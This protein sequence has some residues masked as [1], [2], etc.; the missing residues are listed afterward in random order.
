MKPSD[1]LL[2]LVSLARSAMP[3]SRGRDAAWQIM[4]VERSLGTGRRA[5]ATFLF[6]NSPFRIDEVRQVEQLAARNGLTLLY[7]PLTRPDNAFT[8]LITAGDPATVWRQHRSNIAPTWDNSPFFFQSRG[9]IACAT[10]RRGGG[11]AQDE[12][13]HAGPVRPPSDQHRRDG[14]LHTRSPGAGAPA[15]GCGRDAVKGLV[16]VVLRLPGRG[17]HH[18]RD[19]RSYRN[20]SSF[21]GTDLLA[22][23]RALLSACAPAAWA[24]PSAAASV[25]RRWTADCASCCSRWLPCS[26][27]TCWA[28]PPPLRARAPAA[29]LAHRDCRGVLLP[30]GFVMGMPMPT[31]IRV[32]RR[33]APELIPWPGA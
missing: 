8:R 24:A 33:A 4:I 32:L 23:G 30:L 3:R 22:D 31:G 15:G 20:A 19:R 12:P 17:V 29:R 5:P 10:S 25:S 9:S 27:S 1:Q 16:P 11:M 28:C 26:W 6:K 18:C 2:R 13:G 14:A 7:T 21:S